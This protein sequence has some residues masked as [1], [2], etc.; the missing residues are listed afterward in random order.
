MDLKSRLSGIIEAKM[1]LSDADSSINDVETERLKNTEIVDKTVAIIEPHAMHGEV[2][3][4]IIK[5]FMDL[6]YNVHLLTTISNKETNSLVRCSFDKD[7][8]S[9]FYFS[10]IPSNQGFF[11]LLRRYDYILDE[12]ILTADGYYFAL[13]LE[14]N[15]INKYNKDNVFAICHDVIS[16]QK[17]ANPEIRFLKKKKTFVLKDNIMFE[18]KNLPYIYPIYFG[19]IKTDKKNNNQTNFIAVGG[20]NKENLRNFKLLF[21]AIEKLIDDNLKFNLTIVGVTKDR[22]EKYINEKNKNYLKT[23]GKV[24]FETLFQN[25]EDADYILFNID[26]KCIEYEKYR[27]GGVTGTLN[28]CLGFEKPAIIFNELSEK[29][30]LKNCSLGYDKDLYSCMKKA[31]SLDANRYKTM[32]TNIHKLKE[33]YNKNSLN[34]LKMFLSDDFI[35]RKNHNK[36]KMKK[37]QSI[38][39]SLY[40]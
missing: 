37:E 35:H 18:G 38:K 29:Y 22:I 10:K 32:Q 34:N 24:D 33:I 12:T 31:I 16:I 20:S 17:S 9:A 30:N 27:D 40:D 19:D 3:P 26:S 25:V 36:L 6:G 21:E 11:D 8:F 1:K 2:Y 13:K 14:E 7:R 39:R 15:Y 23:I 28:L 5:Y 4:S